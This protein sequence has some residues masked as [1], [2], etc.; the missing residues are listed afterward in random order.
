MDERAST[1]KVIR[2]RGD[3][4]RGTVLIVEDDVDARE[5][6]QMVL[7]SAGYAVT[8][9][10]NG[11][12]GVGR[13]HLQPRPDVIVCDLMMPVMNGWDFCAAKSRDPEV[14]SIPVVIVS[15]VAKVASRQPSPG[16]ITLAKPLDIDRFLAAIEQCCSGALAS[17]SSVG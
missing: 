3:G 11:L 9:A 17:A 13:L 10:S 14:A 8:T 1:M 5:V 15:A 6:M 2:E 16:D 4:R 7:E 12:E